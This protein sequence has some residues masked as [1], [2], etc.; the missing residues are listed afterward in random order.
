MPAIDPRYL[1][2]EPDQRANVGRLCFGRQI[3]PTAYKARTDALQY[4]IPY[5]T[6]SVMTANSASR[7]GPKLVDKATSAASRP[8][9]INI[10]PVLG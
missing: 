7:A 5:G 4:W 3:L 8:R 1:S 6:S 2:E 9:A 10:R